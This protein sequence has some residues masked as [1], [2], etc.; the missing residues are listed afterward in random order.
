VAAR[1]SAFTFKG[2]GA[3]VA[4]VG[5][6]LNVATVLEG[7]VRKAGNRVRIAVQ[8]VKVADGFHLWSETY[9]RTLEDIFAVQDD[10]AQSVVKELRA[11]L[12]GEQPDSDASG[13][14]RAEVAAAAKGRGESGEAHRLFLEG[15]YLVY[16]LAAED[17]VKGVGLLR[18]AVEVDPGHAQAWACLSFAYSVEAGLG[19]A[20]IAEGNVRARDAARRSLDLEPD[21][22]E[23][24]LALG[25][26]QH[27]HDW[28]WKGAEA[29]YRRAL[30]RAPGNAEALRL[31]AMLSYA[32]GRPDE[33]LALGRRAVEQDPLALTS[34]AFYGRVLRG[35]GRVEEAEKSF[36]RALEISP[37]S[38]SLRILLAWT[39]EAQGRREEA[40]AEAL[41]EKA[42]WARLFALA[43]L[44]HSAGRAA[45]SDQALR[46][47]KEKRAADA[48]FQI[49]MAHA[50]RGEPDA[51]FEWLDRAY[52]LRDSGCTL[53][54]LEPL[55]RPLHSDPR[56]AAFLAKMGLA[57]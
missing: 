3:A 57:D 21:L 4:E 49:A 51:A 39:L 54:K 9:D 8:L 41:A 23:G 7:S 55:L 33:A 27:W 28:D 15:R 46:E 47:L 5:Q 53:C 34:H 13:E 19:F 14:A 48:A 2:K 31:A 30:A 1:S 12:L 22:V 29:S 6:V 42:D 24:H 32:L 17:L 43:I 16:R 36:R 37:D 40:F 35:A 10:I 11:T 25:T 45:E 26:V 52:E 56:W 18:R 20:P 50:M 44:N 38:I